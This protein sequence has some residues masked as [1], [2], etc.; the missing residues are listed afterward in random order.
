[1]WPVLSRTEPVEGSLENMGLCTSSA[2]LLLFF[3]L[4]TWGIYTAQDFWS[5][6][7][8]PDQQWNRGVFCLVLNSLFFLPNNLICTDYAALASWNTAH[9]ILKLSLRAHVQ[10]SCDDPLAISFLIKDVNDS[11]L[12]SCTEN[13]VSRNYQTGSTELIQR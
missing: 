1:M 2:N 10:W 13:D 8:S 5:W 4:I 11:W 7:P 12:P 9:S 3:S 6:Q